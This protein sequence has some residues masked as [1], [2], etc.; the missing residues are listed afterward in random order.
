MKYAADMSSGAMIY[1]PSS[2][3]TASDIQKLMWWGDS[4]TDSMEIA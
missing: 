1:L 4:Q 3:K 2:M